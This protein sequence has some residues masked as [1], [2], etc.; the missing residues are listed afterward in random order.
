MNELKWVEVAGY[1]EMSTIA[2]DCFQRQLSRKPD[3]VLGLATG[4]SPIGFYEKLAERHAQGEL[5]FALAKT[6]NLDEYTGLE[7]SHPASFHSYMEKQFFG[8]VDLPAA[9]RHLPNGMAA[10]LNEE[11]VRYERLIRESGGIDIQLLG[12]GVNGHIGF[13]EPG[14]PFQTRTHIVGLSESTRTVNAKHFP[15]GEDVP[16]KAVTMGIRSILEA[17]QIVL[18]AYGHQKEEAVERL[19]SGVISE[20]FPAS[21]LHG[22][23]R[24]TVL[25]GK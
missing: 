25:Y 11:C 19:K 8:K 22:H 20:E 12:I 13:N 3:S 23:P 7:P 10:D 18:L 2:A 24:V 17:K 4:A 21:C 14:T 15:S 9:Q 16:E 5:S 6:F 1:D